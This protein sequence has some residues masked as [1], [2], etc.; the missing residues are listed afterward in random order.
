MLTDVTNRAHKRGSKSMID[1]ELPRRVTFDNM[2]ELVLEQIADHLLALGQ[3][4]DE[5]DTHCLK[6][7]LRDVKSYSQTSSRLRSTSAALIWKSG[8]VKLDT[9][10]D[11]DSFLSGYADRLVHIRS[12]AFCIG[13]G[14]HARRLRVPK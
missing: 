5:Y 2:P 8:L 11:L 10:A 9:L 1:A 13:E 6:Q 4:V 14:D 3:Q 12:V 7:D